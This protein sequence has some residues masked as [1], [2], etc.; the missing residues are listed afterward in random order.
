MKTKAFI[1]ATVEL[2]LSVFELDPDNSIGDAYVVRD[3]QGNDICYASSYSD[4]LTK[5]DTLS[6]RLCEGSSMFRTA[7]T[8]SEV[9]TTGE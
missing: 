2:Q 9:F 3:Q 4:A 1:V 7:S 6:R 8:S 5:I